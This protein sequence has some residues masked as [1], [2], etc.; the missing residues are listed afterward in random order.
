MIISDLF[1]ILTLMINHVML[2][3]KKYSH[4]RF[5]YFPYN[6]Q[7]YDNMQI[8]TFVRKLY[9]ESNYVVNIKHSL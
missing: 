3:K 1:L 7:Q 5:I 9:F 4:T 2:H 8:V 6:I